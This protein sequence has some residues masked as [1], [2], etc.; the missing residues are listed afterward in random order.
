MRKHHINAN[1]G[2]VYRVPGQYS[3]KLPKLQKIRKDWKKFCPGAERTKQTW[4]L[5]AMLYPAWDSEAGR[6]PQW[7]NCRYPSKGWG[8]VDSNQ[9]V[10]VS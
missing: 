1:G 8:V 2:R 9:P 5:M 6:G 10:L 3:T 4:R 7:E